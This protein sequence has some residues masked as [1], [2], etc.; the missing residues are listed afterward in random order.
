MHIR[1]ARPA[2]AENITATWNWAIAETDAIFRTTPHDP[3][4]RAAFIG[5]LLEQD[6]PF[7]LAEDDDGAYL[8]F[9]FYQPLGNPA[10]WRGSMENTIYVSPAAHGQ[11]VGKALLRELIARARADERV[12]TLIALIV[13]TNAASLQLHRSLGYED[14]GMLREVSHKF[15][16]WIS[17]KYLQ[18]VFDEGGAV[19][20]P[21]N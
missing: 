20:Q 10:V 9:A 8:G 2:D 6:Y 12:H 1:S 7:L 19:P 11:G 4:E 15:G 16:R 14:A 13:S 21:T 18:L 5:D 17:L 3:Q